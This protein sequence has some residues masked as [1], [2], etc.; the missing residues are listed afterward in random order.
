MDLDGDGSGDALREQVS[1]DFGSGF[2]CLP[3]R[4]V[5]VGEHYPIVVRDE[6]YALP[7]VEKE[8]GHERQCR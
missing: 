1:T 3:F 2:G 4:S 6:P 8:A 7:N 5:K